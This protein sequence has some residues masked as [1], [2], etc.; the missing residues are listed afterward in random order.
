MEK[1]TVIYIDWWLGRVIAMSGAI[2]TLADYMY[3]KLI[4]H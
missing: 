1:K 3:S 4:E 2:T